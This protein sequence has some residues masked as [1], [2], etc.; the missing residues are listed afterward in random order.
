L[1][2]PQTR[3]LTHPGS[4]HFFSKPR[5]AEI[6]CAFLQ[7]ENNHIFLSAIQQ[8]S[9]CVR[10]SHYK[11]RG[12]SITR[13]NLHREWSSAVSPSL[14][15]PQAVV[16]CAC[17]LSSNSDRFGASQKGAKAPGR[18]IRTRPHPAPVLYVT[19][20]L[21]IQ[22]ILISARRSYD[23]QIPLPPTFWIFF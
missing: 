23:Q 2:L 15:C 6:R 17:Y 16:S 5:D 18:K 22:L 19:S 13:T 8:C 20:G 4:K 11:S 21:R 9:A 12:E 1:S 14:L 3:T 10:S 7:T